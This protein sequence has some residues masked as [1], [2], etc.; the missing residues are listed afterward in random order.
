MFMIILIPLNSGR[1]SSLPGLTQ[2]TESNKASPLSQL[3]MT[4]TGYSYLDPG[5]RQAK[6]PTNPLHWS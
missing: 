5:L 4:I 3:C 1:R 6:G 2:S